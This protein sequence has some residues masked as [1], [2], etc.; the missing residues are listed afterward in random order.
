[1]FYFL[2]LIADKTTTIQGLF[3]PELLLADPKGP[4]ESSFSFSDFPEDVQLC[5]LSFLSL[6]E[7][8]NF[9]CTSK[10][11]LSLC[12]NDTKIWFTLCQ[13]WWGSLTQI[14]R[15]GGGKITYKLLYKTLTQ[16]EN[17]IGFWRHCGRAGLSGQCPRLIVFEWGPSFVSGSRVCPYKN[18]TYHVTK[19]PFLW[20]GISS[21]GQIVYFLDLEGQ[22]EKPSGD[23]DRWLEFVCLDQNLVPANVNF[24]GKDHF[25]VEENSNFWN[26]CKSKDVLTRSSSSKNLIEDS[27]EVIESGS[28]GSLPDR[29]VSEMYTYFSNRTSPVGDRACRR[30]RKKEKERQGMRKWE[31]EH[32]LK[33]VDCSPTPDKSLQGLWKGISGGRNLNFYLVKYD[34]IGGIIC[35]RIGDFSSSYTLVLWTSELTLMESPFSAAEENIYVDRIHLQPFASE[36]QVHS[37]PTM[38]DIEMASH[39]LHIK[40]SCNLILPSLV[41]S[42]GLQHREGRIWQYINGTFG[43]GFLHD[44][45][46]TDLK[47]VI[48]DGLLLDSVNLLH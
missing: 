16:W 4:N 37:L 41:G 3:V 29:L 27:D 31:P 34:E 35:Q 47:H 11:F 32:F 8:A 12:R 25:I 18:G 36:D 2:A 48:E 44:H 1:M 22:A 43:F 42:A 9:A 17:L 21:D 19:A 20:M 14:N 46:I 23:F 10:R 45:F 24:M 5:I 33:V 39:I 30:Q 38:T 7:I 28:A 6:S 40:S 15:W 13:R 26:S